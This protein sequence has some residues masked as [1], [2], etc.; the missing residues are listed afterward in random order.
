MSFAVADFFFYSGIALWLFLG[1]AA[2]AIVATY[3]MEL[4]IAFLTSKR[5]S[6]S[7]RYQ[8]RGDRE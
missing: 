8:N 2:A 1:V 6:R 7:S 4:A 3:L 5:Y